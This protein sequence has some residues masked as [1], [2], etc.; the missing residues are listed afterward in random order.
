MPSVKHFSLGH[1]IPTE[2]SYVGRRSGRLILRFSETGVRAHRIPNPWAIMRNRWFNLK[3]TLKKLSSGVPGNNFD[4]LLIPMKLKLE[5]D[6]VASQQTWTAIN[7]ICARTSW[8]TSG[9]P[10]CKL[11]PTANSGPIFVLRRM[12][13]TLSTVYLYFHS[14]CIKSNGTTSTKRTVD[15]DLPDAPA[16][17]D[18]DVIFNVK[19]FMARLTGILNQMEQMVVSS[20]L[21]FP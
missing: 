1:Q 5:Y 3:K 16:T 19:K 4:D 15:S 6:T 12:R 9:L 7:V 10:A 14:L 20:K 21:Q 18:S 17:P 2:M 13:S 8:S 11:L